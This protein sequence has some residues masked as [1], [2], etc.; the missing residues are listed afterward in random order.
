MGAYSPL[1]WLPA[2]TVEEIIDTVAQPVIDEMARRGTPFTGLLYCGLAMTSK[3]LRV[4]EFNVRFGDPE[5]Q[6]VLARLRSPLGQTLLAAAEGR[7]DEV[8]D[9]EW[10]PRASVTV[11]IAAENYPGA[12]STGDIVRGLDTAETLEDISVQHA[13]TKIATGSSGG[14]APE[15]AVITKDI[16]EAGD[17]VTAGGRV[18]SVVSLGSDLDDARA[19]GVL[20]DRGDQMAR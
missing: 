3:G 15:D 1:P 4:V 6:S 12:P 17:I 20:S 14:F 9:L 8:G 18:L 2:G 13:G 16:A 7:L 10:D 5:T 11:V 19:Q